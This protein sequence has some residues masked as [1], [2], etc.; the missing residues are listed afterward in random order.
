V[1]GAT[2]SWNIL[3]PDPD[4]VD[5]VRHENRLAEP[6]ARALVNRG[7][8]DRAEIRQYLNPRLAD[9]SP[10]FA[11]PGLR[12]AAERLWRAIDAG[13]RI[14]VYGDYDV[15][16]ITSTALMFRVLTVLGADAV[17]FIP[18]RTKDGYGLSVA[19][20][21]HC[22]ETF[23]PSVIITVDCGTGSVEAV[24]AA[25]E[26]GIHVIVTDHHEPS[27]G[28]A[29]AFALINP[30][31]CECDEALG[32][33]AGVGVA[34]KL[35]H[36]LVA[37]GRE[38]ERA[39]TESFDLRPYTV[40][41]ALGTIADVVPL[42]GENRALVRTGLRFLNQST[43]P[44]LRALKE[45][46]KINGEVRGHH[47]GF[48]IGPRL[49]AA[50]RMDDPKVALELLL[51]DSYENALATAR[52][53][54]GA[55]R[56][57]Q[58]VEV[59]IYNAA[60]AQ[61]DETFDPDSDYALV[62]AS[63]G[64]HPGVIGIVASRLVGK[65]NRPAVVIA[66]DDEGVG[67]GSCRSID[68]FDMVEGLQAVSGF[69]LK[70]GG[71][72][73]AAGLEIDG[74]NVAEF[75]QKLNEVARLQIGDHPLRP[76]QRIDGKLDASLIDN[77]F[78]DVL[79]SMA[80]FGNR[81]PKPVWV[82]EGLHIK[83]GPFHIKDRHLKMTLDTGRGEIDAFGFNMAERVFDP[84]RPVNVVFKLERS[85]Y[86]GATKLQLNLVDFESA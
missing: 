48:V 19:A 27:G 38:Q 2:K 33:L 73:M 51:E 29:A 66:L 40:F 63:H 69:L 16:G 59:A 9:L 74:E 5:R 84:T 37:V 26:A 4:L 42:Y 7:F 3:E 17:T 31:Y 81:N 14:L 58:S 52:Q 86:M 65:Y 44:G 35:C 71:H 45:V 36:A 68:T 43:P 23:A 32:I 6:V 83:H 34:F 53:L 18:H 30:K 72:R 67:K 56:E 57:R 39:A 15:D 61:I 22:R 80:P 62:A 55:N 8:I 82:C 28:V 77:E 79:E 47:I 60:C 50:G 85:S 54:D 10:P 12:K 64:W 76:T 46:C 70:F 21:E 24:E 78:F 13:E 1:A 49:N 25:N 20:F 41:A 11:I 75:R